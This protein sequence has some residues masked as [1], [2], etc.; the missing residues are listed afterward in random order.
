MYNI[1]AMS[2]IK[3]TNLENSYN[4]LKKCYEDYLQNQNSQFL[5]YICDACVKRFEYTLETSWKIMKK[6]FIKKYGKT[7]EELTINNIFRFMQ[8]YEYTK[9]W[10]N[11]KNYYS[12]RNNTAHEYN[13]EKSRELIKII[14]DFLSDMEFLLIALKA[15]DNNE[16]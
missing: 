16:D 8:G 3:F 7:E 4:T 15:K 2:E 5:E 6:L 11:W 9:N 10:L 14:P 13:I 12:T 1:T